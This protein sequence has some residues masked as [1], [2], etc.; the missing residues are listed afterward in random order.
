MFQFPEGALQL[1]GL[2]GRLVERLGG[3]G[4]L[5]LG[6]FG[7]VLGGLGLLA[8]CLQRGFGLLGG[9]GQGGGLGVRSGKFKF[10]MVRHFAGGL[11]GTGQFLEFGHA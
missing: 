7:G 1:Q 10:G 5:R 2:L 9:G 11:D 4:Y 6:R 8:G 3:D